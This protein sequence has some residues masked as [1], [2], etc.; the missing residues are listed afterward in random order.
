MGLID[1]R[2]FIRFLADQYEVIEALSRMS[3]FTE[4]E[5]LE[6]TQEFDPADLMRKGLLDFTPET[7]EYS[8]HPTVSQLFRELNRKRHLSSGH[9]TQIHVKKLQVLLEAMDRCLRLRDWFNFD[10]ELESL[11]RA[12]VEIHADVLGNLDAIRKQTGAIRE[13]PWGGAKKRLE[14]LSSLWD[15]QIQPLEGVFVPHGPVD[16]V[17][18]QIERLLKRAELAAIGNPV[19]EGNLRHTYFQARRLTRSAR[20][21]HMEAIREVRPLYEAAKRNEQVAMAASALVLGCFE[22]RKQA[23][24]LYADRR[25]GTHVLDAI[26]GIQTTANDGEERFFTP[27]SSDEARTLLVDR[28]FGYRPSPPPVLAPPRHEVAPFVLTEG[29]TR[30]ALERATAAGPVPDV[31][32]WLIETFPKASLKDVIRAYGWIVLKWGGKV[33]PHMDAI[34]RKGG[35]R[36]L[37][38]PVESRPTVRRVS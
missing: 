22:N 25:N 3:R 24:P 5:F 6:V 11:H 14:I 1:P 33:A 13:T 34:N 2:K 4:S 32:A 29:I 23:M 28:F 20:D 37:S 12:L 18:E 8:L 36:I 30:R 27:F 10:V 21:A 19:A 31:M 26:F 35:Y 15:N 38:H 7:S 17:L 16:A 9:L